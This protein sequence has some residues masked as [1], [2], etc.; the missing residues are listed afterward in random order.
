MPQERHRRKVKKT[1]KNVYLKEKHI[2]HIMEKCGGARKFSSYLSKIIDLYRVLLEE[3]IINELTDESI[4]NFKKDILDEYTRKALSKMKVLEYKEVFEELVKYSS[5]FIPKIDAF[6]N[7]LIHWGDLFSEVN[8][9]SITKNPPETEE[10]LRKIPQASN[11]VTSCEMNSKE[12]YVQFTGDM[13]FTLL[14]YTKIMASILSIS[15]YHWEIIKTI[16]EDLSNKETIKKIR[17]YLKKGESIQKSLQKMYEIFS[18]IEIRIKDKDKS[19]IWEMLNNPFHFIIDGEFLK[20]IS[21]NKE[22]IPYK[23]YIDEI[24]KVKNK[25]NIERVALVLGFYSKINLIF[26][27]RVQDNVAIFIPAHPI[28]TEIIEDTFSYLKINSN[29]KTQD[30]SI[31][32]TFEP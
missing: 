26:Q 23:L 18:N 15:N 27:L 32:L 9:E 8:L 16:P 4:N 12:L 19:S 31:S 29:L 10:I 14:W 6:P 5:H 24:N 25:S 7:I 1:A 22:E 3:K 11:M 13:P 30:A 17:I 2:K 20:Y 28:M 21:G